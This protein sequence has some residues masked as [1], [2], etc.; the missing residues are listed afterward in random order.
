M[1]MHFLTGQ[2][3]AAAG[4]VAPV[5]TIASVGGFLGPA[6]IGYLKNRAETHTIAFIL[7]GAAALVA[8]LLCL[9]LRS[10]TCH[11]VNSLAS[12]R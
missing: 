4:E 12:S 11:A 9:W 7:L 8:G 6:L 1:P 10:S 2:A 3:A 5:A